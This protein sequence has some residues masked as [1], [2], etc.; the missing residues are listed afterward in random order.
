MK[1]RVFVIALALILVVVVPCTAKGPKNNYGG[2]VMQYA[3]GTADLEGYVLNLCWDPAD[4][5][6]TGATEPAD[7]YSVEV[8][9]LMDFSF[10]TAPTTVTDFEAEFEYD[11][12]DRCITIDLEEDIQNYIG[13]Y[14]GTPVNSFSFG[15]VYAKVKGLD[16]EH[17]NPLSKKRQDNW[18]SEPADL[19]GLVW[20]L[21]TLP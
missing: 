16:T 19:G 20:P 9:G 5:Q 4:V 21:P 11:T 7:K 10:G 17:K 14:Y 18:F 12:T 13:F 1:A 2:D 8:Y 15:T 6:P 3:F